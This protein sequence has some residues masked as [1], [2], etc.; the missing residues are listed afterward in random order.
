MTPLTATP[1]ALPP[2]LRLPDALQAILLMRY[3]PTVMRRLHKRHGDVFSVRMPYGPHGSM[4]TVVALADPED[5]RQVF[6]GDVATYHAGEGNSSLLD[7]MGEHSLLLL[8]EGQHAR[9][10]KLLTPAFTTG[11]LNG[12]RPMFADLAR[13]ELARWSDGEEFAAIGRMQSITLE[14]ILR[15]VFGV[16]DAARLTELRPL[17]TKIAN[18]DLVMLLA[19]RY[20]RLQKLPPWR[21]Y[22]AAQQELDD[23]LYAEIAARRADPT[24]PDRDDLL[25]RLLRPGDDGDVL[26]DAELRDQLIT[27]LLAGHE[28]TA[29]SLAWALHELARHPGAMRRAQEAADRVGGEGD[30]YLEAV[31]KEAMRLR[32]VLFQA[33]RTLTEDTGVAGHRLPAGVVVSPAL[34]LVGLSEALHDGAGEFRPERFLD[35]NPAPNTWIPFGGGPRRCIGAAFSLVESVEILRELLRAFEIEAVR[36]RPETL[37]PRGIINAPSRG[38]QLRVSTRVS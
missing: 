6:A 38:S 37:R 36:T 35:S 21:A 19:W 13:A 4:V 7:V 32:P 29:T 2:G 12:Y 30:K 15:V 34:G 1:A 16:T 11:A 23:L 5:I 27:F 10:R 20:P 17:V 18:L 31:V 25:S 3:R 8:D 26:T 14:I 22:A 24:T 33:T 28:T 9:A